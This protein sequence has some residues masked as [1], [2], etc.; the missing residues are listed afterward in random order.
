[1]REIRTK[2]IAACSLA[3]TPDKIVEM[4]KVEFNKRNLDH[5]DGEKNLELGKKIH[6][7]DKT[8]RLEMTEK[9]VK[10]V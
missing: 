6:P 8:V 10:G 5:D 3:I 7:Y 2:A 1:M 9:R 4:A